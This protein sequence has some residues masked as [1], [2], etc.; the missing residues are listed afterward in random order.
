MGVDATA[1]AKG[2]STAVGGQKNLNTSFSAMNSSLQAKWSAA[3][4]VAAAKESGQLSST[5]IGGG[6]QSTN[7]LTGIGGLQSQR[8]DAQEDD[9]LTRSQNQALQNRLSGSSEVTASNKD[10]N[11]KL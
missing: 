3:K 4:N 9:G 8:L 1:M 7:R 2:K 11:K 10:L 6:T 5:M